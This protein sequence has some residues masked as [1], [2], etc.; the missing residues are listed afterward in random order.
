MSLPMQG[1][2]EEIAKQR[3]AQFA[4]FAES[5]KLNL[6]DFCGGKDDVD[7]LFE[8]MRERY[9]G[10]LAPLEQKRQL[11]LLFALLPGK[12]PA[13]GIR[14]L[15]GG[16]D[17]LTVDS[18]A[19]VYGGAGYDGDAAPPRVRSRDP[20]ADEGETAVF[21]A[22]LETT[23]KL[24]G[25]SLQDRGDG[26]LPQAPP[27][28]SISPPRKGGAAR[29]ATALAV[30]NEDGFLE[31]VILIDPGFGYTA[32]QRIDVVIDPP[33]LPSASTAEGDEREEK[34]VASSRDGRRAAVGRALLD[35]KIADVTVK[36]AGSG[37][38]FASVTA[39]SSSAWA[40]VDAP[41]DCEGYVA[42]SDSLAFPV[43]ED[44]AAINVDF[45]SIS[46]GRD[47]VAAAM[48]AQRRATTGYAMGANGGLP[49]V[50]L[51]PSGAFRL[52]RRDSVSAALTSLLPP[53]TPLLVGGALAKD[54]PES[55]T[56]NVIPFSDTSFAVDKKGGP[57]FVVAAAVDKALAD[58]EMYN[59]EYGPLSIP[60]AS[61]TQLSS[62]A[63]ADS[64]TRTSA[65]VFGP[66]GD[67]PL[68][69]DLSYSF[70]AYTRLALSAA[71]CQILT[72]GVLTPLELTKSRLQAMP[73]G[74]APAAPLPKG[75]VAA[76]AEL[77]TV[78]A[79]KLLVRQCMNER[80]LLPAYVGYIPTILGGVCNGA[81]GLAINE[82]MRQ[83]L[84]KQ[85][86]LA[87]GIASVGDIPY[88][89][90]LGIIITCA[91]ASSFLNSIFLTPLEAVRIAVQTKD[92]DA[93]LRRDVPEHSH[94]ERSQ[95]PDLFAAI[96]EI[97]QRDPD[98]G[99]LAF[100][101]GFET[102]LLREL[103][104]VV[105]KFLAYEAITSLAYLATPGAR[106]DVVLSLVVS[107]GAGVVAGVFGSFLSNPADYILTIQQGSE[108]QGSLKALALDVLEKDG[109]QAFLRGL[110][111]RSV[112]FGLL[113]SVQFFLYDLFKV[114]FGVSPNDMKLVLDV[115][116]ERL[117]M[118]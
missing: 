96:Q 92:M 75:A 1:K 43:P 29:P 18:V 95:A 58:A 76:P 55:S 82:A 87:M 68:E 74:P 41:E 31:G 80:S 108:N 104:F 91:M 8:I 93:L 69:M 44:R 34:E 50:R 117:T 40:V 64:I 103:P 79:L 17:N 47:A 24:R 27:K 51:Q 39:W 86:G 53:D 62:G 57:T 60:A 20:D 7:G 56:D 118:P 97:S 5:V 113:I 54:F 10:P 14:D 42:P 107:V 25:V 16:I 109:P 115:F 106:E 83:A 99:A 81:V 71:I 21:S 111:V 66:V 33:P 61:A 22:K 89:Y 63:W 88:L 4:E 101:D 3:T 94:A 116:A 36:N 46:L 73:S 13:A 77:N 12:Q 15:L 37:Y 110:G 38:A 78:S 72:R 84:A 49:N 102:M 9:A 23:G 28:V 11:A 98:R 45:T 105:G 90:T 65:D 30:V 19:V 52:L 100:M 35:F 6:Y 112:Y 70:P 32:D 48:S 2:Q 114:A 85:V 59:P 67:S 26:Y